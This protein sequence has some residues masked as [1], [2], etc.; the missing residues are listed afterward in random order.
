MFYPL[1]LM[2]ILAGQRPARPLGWRRAGGLSLARARHGR[3]R[4]GACG[5][6][7]RSPPGTGRLP[8]VFRHGHGGR[9]R[10]H[11]WHGAVYRTA[12]MELCALHPAFGGACAAAGG[13]EAFCIG[14]ELRGVTQMR[15][16]A[17]IPGGRPT[18]GSG[19]GGPSAFARC[20]SDLC[21]RLVGVFRASAA[22][23]LW[24]R[25]VPP[26]SALVGRQHRFHRDRQ[27]H[28]AVGLAG[29]HGP[30]RCGV[31]LDLGSG[32]PQGEYRGRRRVGLV[33]SQRHRARGAASRSRSPTGRAA[34]PGSTATRRCGTG[35]RTSMSTGS[36]RCGALSFRAAMSPWAGHRALAR[37]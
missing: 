36:M 18:G 33:L 31:V 32:I 34:R 7:R 20:R 28:A 24:R 26:R 27:L 15:D 9:F 25:G 4:P 23:R 5:K 12:G 37:R 22:G 10:G 13:V 17:G 30:C 6:H 2:E 14:S 19:R 35:G 3:D 8:R 16:E 21:R 1:M 29:R 11:G